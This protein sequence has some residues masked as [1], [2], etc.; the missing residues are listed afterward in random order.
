VYYRGRRND[1]EAYGCQGLGSTSW[2][3]SPRRG[4]E[5]AGRKLEILTGAGSGRRV[6]Q[7]THPLVASLPASMVGPPW[8]GLVGASPGPTIAELALFSK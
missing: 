6:A 7:W 1:K 4:E 3:D 2:L 5:S 8:V